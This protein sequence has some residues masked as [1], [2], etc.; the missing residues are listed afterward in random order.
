MLRH[1]HDLIVPQEWAVITGSRWYRCYGPGEELGRLFMQALGTGQARIVAMLLDH[2]IPL[3]VIQSPSALRYGLRCHNWFK[4]PGSFE[5]LQVM[6]AHGADVNER[7]KKGTLLH[8]HIYSAEQDAT[9]IQLLLALGADTEALDYN[10]YKP[11]RVAV[12]AMRTNR[13]VESYNKDILEALLAAGADMIN[14]GALHYAAIIGRYEALEA[15][16]CAGADPSTVYVGPVPLKKGVPLG[17]TVREYHQEYR[18][19][20]SSG[21]AWSL[22]V[23]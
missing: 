19:R 17:K 18:E 15:M 9:T 6:V 14:S 5:L 4:N 23:S 16:I 22:V 11:L 21:L 2:G 20:L 3:G 8:Q 12:N 7:N 13:R 10:G 1:C